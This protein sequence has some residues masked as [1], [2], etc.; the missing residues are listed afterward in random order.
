MHIV[1]LR[2]LLPPFPHVGNLE[3]CHVDPSLL[4]LRQDGSVLLVH[5]SAAERRDAAEVHLRM[6]GRQALAGDTGSRGHG[7][8]GRSP[9]VGVVGP[10][11]YQS[12]TI[13]EL[14]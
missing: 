2:V 3:W 10:S 9:V 12:G 4:L 13:G 8:T 14:V 11:W 6:G 7:G 1:D 5:G